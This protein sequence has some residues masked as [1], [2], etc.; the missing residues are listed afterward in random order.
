MNPYK[1]IHAHLNSRL[2]SPGMWTPFHQMHIT[3]LVQF[4][5]RALP[6]QYRAIPERSLQIKIDDIEQSRPRPDVTVYEQYEST[7]VPSPAVATKPAWQIDLTA[8]TEPE[9]YPAIVIRTADDPL[10]GKVVTRIELL[11]PS[12]K[13]GGAGYAA[14]RLKRG[15]ALKSDVP[16]VEIDYLHESRSPIEN[17][18]VYPTDA[19][20]FPYTITVTK[21]QQQV[22]GYTARVDNPLPTVPIPLLGDAFANFSFDDV[23]QYTIGEEPWRTLITRDIDMQQPPVR[24]ETYSADDQARVRRVMAR[25]VD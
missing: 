19:A 11:S 8:E 12:N 15:E 25:I 23:Y 6:D 2:Q 18:P 13:P 21:P 20:A 16:L 14:Y 4:L 9:M 3:F 22:S 1:G 17:A 5:N 10:F 7:A 24:F